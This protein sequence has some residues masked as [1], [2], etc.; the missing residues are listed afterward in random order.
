MICVKLLLE[1]L[2]ASLR[3]R[4]ETL[5]RCIQSMHDVLPL[6]RV[7]LFGSHARGTARADSDV[8]LCLIADGAQSQ[9]NAA[10]EWRM[11]MRA[12]R[13]KP[14]FT[15]VPITPGRLR[16]KEECGDPFFKTVLSEGVL[17]A[18]ED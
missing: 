10:A 6:R 9:L 11:A 12:V 16:E 3:G 5:A 15:L 7:I 13:P 18:Q 8:D 14:S 1:N 2:P 4:Q 17:L